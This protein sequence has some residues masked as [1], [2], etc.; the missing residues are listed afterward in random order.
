MPTRIVS[1]AYRSSSIE[2]KKTAALHAIPSCIR[3]ASGGVGHFRYRP[4]AEYHGRR[5]DGLRGVPA[6]GAWPEPADP[7]STP[8]S[9][10][11]TQG[12]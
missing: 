12:A 9:Y 5:E 6:F 11:S 1:G 2:K 4:R 7:F 3:H 8:R 10:G